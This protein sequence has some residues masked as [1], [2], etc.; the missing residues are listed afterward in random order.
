MRGRA[1]TLEYRAARLLHTLALRLRTK[2]AAKGKKNFFAVW[3][4]CCTCL[5]HTLTYAHT[6]T[7]RDH[8]FLSSLCLSRYIHTYMVV[9][10][11][12]PLD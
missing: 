6:H 10:G 5:A 1:Q 9:G 4:E 3:N 12:I 8:L 11:A 2:V 7:C